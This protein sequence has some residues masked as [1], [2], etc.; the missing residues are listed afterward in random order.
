[1]ER[2]D[3]DIFERLAPGG[4]ARALQDVLDP[5]ELVRLAN[6]CGLKYRGMRTQ[7]QPRERLVADLVDR[8]STHLTARRAIVRVLEKQTSEALRQWEALGA[9]EKAGR[10]GDE[11]FLRADGNLGLHLF[12]L[13]AAADGS[14]LDRFGAH[15]ARQSLLRMAGNGAAETAEAERPSRDTGRLQRRVVELEKKTRHLEAQLAKTREL[16][17]TAKRDLIQ[18]KGELAESRM[19]AERLREEAAAAQ[20]A[21]HVASAGRKAPA[22]AA[23]ETLAELARAVRKLESGQKKVAHELG[24]LA[25]AAVPPAVDGRAVVALGESAARLEKEL[26]QQRQELRKE[27]GAQTKQVEELRKEIAALAA[28]PAAGAAARRPS[29]R[30]RA[31]GPTARVGVFIDVQNVYYGARQLKGKLDFDALM[32]AA[33]ADRRLI[34]ATAYVVESKEIDRSQFI[35]RLL[36]RGIRVQRKSLKVRADGSMKGDWDVEMALDALDAAPSLDVV[37]LV[38]GDGDFTSLVERVRS[39]G[40]RVEVIAFPRN[41]SKAL[42]QAADHFQPLD[43]KFMIYPRKGGKP[44]AGESEPAAGAEAGAGAGTGTEAADQSHGS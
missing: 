10:L 13:A 25:T 14:D 6:A 19:L 16:H 41:T 29:R 42:A 26:G 2:P 8:A 22:A 36:D 5:S 30:T 32:Q 28:E 31:K 38:S 18:R 24:R 17:K 21:A 4:L 3:K 11:A 7:S 35:A 1:M 39:I 33:V 15:F 37:V 20:T 43:R 12:L 44:S 40:P 9:D 23:D 27:L 34:Q